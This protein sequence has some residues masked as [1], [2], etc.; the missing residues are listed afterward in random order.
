MTSIEIDLAPTIPGGVE[1]VGAAAAFKEQAGVEATRDHF[2]SPRFALADD[3]G[4]VTLG[5]WAECTNVRPALL[6]EPIRPGGTR[7]ERFYWQAARPAPYGP[8]R[9]LQPLHPGVAPVTVEWALAGRGGRP[10]Q[11]RLAAKTRPIRATTAITLTGDGPGVPSGPELLD[12]ALADPAWRSWV[13]QDRTGADVVVEVDALR[14][15]P[16]VINANFLRRTLLEGIAPNGALEIVL[17]TVDTF[18]DGQIRTWLTMAAVYLD[19]W[20]GEVIGTWF[21]DA[22]A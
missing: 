21:R 4:G 16:Y 18:G 17:G 5:I 15:P 20:T 13:E 9:M 6:A 19:P 22:P 11:A 12:A 3:A 1:Q 14:G 2:R 8:R 10:D 7:T